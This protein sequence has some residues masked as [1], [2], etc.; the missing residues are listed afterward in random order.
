MLD[1]AGRYCGLGFMSFHVF[2]GWK[3]GNCSKFRVIIR[4]SAL[5]CP[6]VRQCGTV[7]EFFRLGVHEFSLQ[8]NCVLRYI[9]CVSYINLCKKYTLIVSI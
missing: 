2:F 3:K 6:E 1:S 7:L 4:S 5:T 9:R 8:S